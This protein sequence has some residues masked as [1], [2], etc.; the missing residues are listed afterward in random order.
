[1][2]YAV[3]LAIVPPNPMSDLQME[4]PVLRRRSTAHSVNGAVLFA[5]SLQPTPPMQIP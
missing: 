1:M 3:F 5:V 4:E 2:L